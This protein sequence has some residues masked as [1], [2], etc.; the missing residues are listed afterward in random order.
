MARQDKGDYW[1]ELRACSYYDKF[2]KSKIFYQAFQTKPCF[3]YDEGV[4]YCNNSIWLL[5]TKSKALLAL[6]NSRVGW[7]LV[8]EFC[9]RIQNGYQLIWD[10][11]SQIPIPRELP[12]ELEKLAETLIE[13]RRAGDNLSYDNLMKELNDA[14]SVMY[15][16]SQELNDNIQ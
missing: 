11:I 7:W 2:E 10:N 12:E 5:T 14:V 1:W 3:I 6:L 4:T 16:D 8:S 9:P 13:A 15:L